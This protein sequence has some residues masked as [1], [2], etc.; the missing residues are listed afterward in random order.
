MKVRRQGY[1]EYQQRK[2]SPRENRDR[3]LTAK[4]KNIFYEAK[5]IYGARK[6]REELRKGGESRTF[7]ERKKPSR[8]IGE[9][10][11]NPLFLCKG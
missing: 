8:K 1:Y 3:M 11:K 4:I 5:R 10:R 2:G 7:V 9:V 6:I